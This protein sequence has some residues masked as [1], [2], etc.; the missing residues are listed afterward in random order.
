MKKK[1]VELPQSKTQ[2][3]VD[4][5]IIREE[6]VEEE[7]G[8]IVVEAVVEEEE[9]VVVVRQVEDL[10]VEEDVEDVVDVEVRVM[11]HKIKI[12]RMRNMPMTPVPLQMLLQL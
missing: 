10:L 6:E 9:E 12:L 5:V 2:T 4:V 1:V 11:L 3:T 7:A 8:E